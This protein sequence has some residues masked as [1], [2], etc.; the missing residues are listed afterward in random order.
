MP[1]QENAI[2]EFTKRFSDQ[3]IMEP[4]ISAPS[5]QSTFRS[6]PFSKLPHWNTANLTNS[7]STF[8]RSCR[9]FLKQSPERMVGN[10]WFHLH[11][12]DWLPACKAAL[13]LQSPTSVDAQ[14]FFETWFQAV[15]FSQNRSPQGLFTGYY[16]PEIK[17]SLTKTKE[18]SVPVYG[19]PTNLIQI[20]LM[21]FDAKL[22]KRQLF[23]RLEKNRL[24]P[25]YS[26]KEIDEGKIDGYAPVI[27]YIHSRVD[28]L[29]MEIQGSVLLRLNDNSQLNL[30]YAGK[31][32]HPYTAIG[33]VLIKR[34][35]L[36]KQTL[37]KQNIEAYLAAHP[38]EADDILHHNRSFV[39][40]EIL[41]KKGAY[42]TQGVTLTPGYSLAVDMDWVP[43]G[44]PVWLNTSFPDPHQ[45]NDSPL[46]R[47]M[48]AQDTGGAIKGMI[49]GDVFWGKGKKAEAIAGKMKN[50]GHYWLLIPK[51][52]AS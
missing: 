37:S 28:R 15:A 44:M 2:T 16:V 26:R 42:G 49:R 43:L 27:A 31:N 17:A 14:H 41:D 48:I 52:Q 23:G 25:F 36:T 9:C 46:H 7:L 13:S 35:I 51:K 29:F 20:N 4:P 33:G 32:G 3:F 18:Y 45:N 19:I 21:D 11:V 8:Q 30:G 47:L 1:I 39:F 34:G 38:E 10:Q 40:F 50:Q 6:V 24:V 5:F 12:K 22:P